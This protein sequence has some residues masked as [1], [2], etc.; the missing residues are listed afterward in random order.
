MSSSELRRAALSGAR[1]T[2]AAKIGLQLL[3][4]P[5]TILVIRLLEPADY[6]LL[7]MAMVT[8]GFVALFG[9]MGLGIA[10][11]QADK[12][13]ESTAR[14]ASAAI[15]ICNVVMAGAIA[16]LAPLAALWFGSPDVI[17]VMRVLTLELLITSIGAVPQ[18]QLERQLRFR[19]LSVATI[20]AGIAGAVITLVLAVSGAGVWALV[21]G[22]LAIALVRTVLIV[23]ANG[24]IVWPSMRHPLAP[25]KGLVRFSSHVLAARMLW[26][27]YGQSDQVILARLL[28]ASTF[29]HYNVAAQLAML[30][31][32]KAMEVINRV[33]FPVLSRMRGESGELSAMHVRLI[34][35]VSTYAFGTCWGMAAVSP[36]LVS[37]LLGSKWALATLPL[38]VLAAVA[39]LRMLSA[40]NNTIASVAGAPQASTI[41]LAVAGSVLPIAVS[42]GAYVNG[43]IGACLAWPLAYPIVYVLS[44]ALTVAPSATRACRG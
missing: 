25:I 34:G 32:N 26:Y 33:T 6:G 23:I 29:G 15:L 13:D 36:E 4:W 11:V 12:L 3:T 17:D 31:A 20:W 9:E 35:L 21:F 28:H 19:S 16:L 41:E 22:T 5:I 14:A 2:L 44:N 10:L 38:T 39:P 18:A 43:L 7:A 1:W 37:T 30:P 24:R 8:I 40:L 27:W 42:I